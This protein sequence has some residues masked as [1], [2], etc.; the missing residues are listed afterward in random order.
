LT[1]QIGTYAGVISA[2]RDRISGY[3]RR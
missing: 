3:A 1:E 2:S